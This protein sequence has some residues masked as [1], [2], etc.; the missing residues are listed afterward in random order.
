MVFFLLFNRTQ[1]FMNVSKQNC[2]LAMFQFNKVVLQ[3]IPLAALIE[4]A[5]S[6]PCLTEG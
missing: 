2:V 1:L 5:F 3:G 4:K 6:C